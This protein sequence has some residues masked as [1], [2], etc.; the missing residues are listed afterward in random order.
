[1]EID[2]NIAENGMRGIA[3]GRKNW[4]HLGSEE[5]GPKVSAILSILETCKRLKINAREYLE[6]VLP[7]IAG[8]NSSR[9]AELTPMAWQRARKTAAV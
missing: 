8:W 7:R 3:L 9:I 6:E 4:I 5:A 2:N 1:V